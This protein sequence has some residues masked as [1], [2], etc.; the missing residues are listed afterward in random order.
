[1]ITRGLKV[2]AA[3]I[4]WTESRGET[5]ESEMGAA[6]RRAAERACGERHGDATELYRGW[7][8]LVADRD[9]IGRG[10]AL[11]LWDEVSAGFAGRKWKEAEAARSVIYQTLISV[12]SSLAD[13]VHGDRAGQE[14]DPDEKV[15]VEAVE[16]GLVRASRDEEEDEVALSS[17]YALLDLVTEVH[18]SNEGPG[19]TAAEWAEAACR[20]AQA[21]KKLA[22][23]RKAAPCAFPGS[24]RAGTTGGRDAARVGLA[25]RAAAA[26]CERVLGRRGTVE[27]VSEEIVR[28]RSSEGAQSRDDLARMLRYHAFESRVAQ[29][30][31]ARYASELELPPA[32]PTTPIGSIGRLE[33]SILMLGPHGVGKTSF[34]FASEALCGSASEPAAPDGPYPPI[35]IERVRN[36]ESED[37]PERITEERREAWLKGDKSRDAFIST[38]ARV[39]PKGLCSYRI[40]DTMGE[41]V[42]KKHERKDDRDAIAT[43]IRRLRDPGIVALMVEAEGHDNEKEGHD[44]ENRVKLGIEDTARRVIELLGRRRPSR[45]PTVYLIVNKLDVR[46]NAKKREQEPQD[47]EAVAAL[48]EETNRRVFDLSAYLDTKCADRALLPQPAWTARVLNWIRADA[49]LTGNLGTREIILENVQRWSNLLRAVAGAGVSEVYLTFASSL[50]D[51]SGTAGQATPSVNAF[52]RHLWGPRQERLEAALASHARSVFCRQARANAMA[53]LE[54]AREG[55]GLQIPVQMDADTTGRPYRAWPGP[56]GDEIWRLIRRSAMQRGRGL[57]SVLA[58]LSSEHRHLSEWRD[59]TIELIRRLRK[60]WEHLIPRAVAELNLDPAWPCADLGPEQLSTREAVNDKLREWLEKRRRPDTNGND[61]GAEAKATTRSVD[62]EIADALNDLATAKEGGKFDKEAIEIVERFRARLEAKGDEA[63]DSYWAGRHRLKQSDVDGYYGSLRAGSLLA[64]AWPWPEQAMELSAWLAEDEGLSIGERVE[65]EIRQAGEKGLSPQTRAVIWQLADHGPCGENPERR[66]PDYGVFAPR[67]WWETERLLLRTLV[68]EKSAAGN[69]IKGA[70]R[71]LDSLAWIAAAGLDEGGVLETRVREA[72]RSFLIARTFQA[73]GLKR[74]AWEDN[75]TD[76]GKA[77]KN[78]R[79]ELKRKHGSVKEWMT[80]KWWVPT[81][82]T[83]G[84]ENLRPYWEGETTANLT[85]SGLRCYTRADRQLEFIEACL[86]TLDAIEGTPIPRADEDVVRAVKRICS[87][88]ERQCREHNKRIA[89]YA[90]ETAMRFLEVYARWLGES[91]RLTKEEHDELDRV[92]YRRS[93]ATFDDSVDAQPERTGPLVSAAEVDEAIE[94]FGRI[95]SV[96]AGG[97]AG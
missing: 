9:R 63:D 73:M 20:E 40:L 80:P 42:L 76:L 18:R 13:R 67:R 8:R 22:N 51:Q 36:T 41:L 90:E 61:A 77:V 47:A 83:E 23:N 53:A 82:L 24:P 30:L 54:L 59:R 64:D 14:I 50:P 58:S 57:D 4:E 70:I 85:G 15:W 3:I 94:V 11:A 66:V 27:E 28:I 10:T 35:A 43:M 39:G 7:T 87:P 44:N 96:R 65:G 6:M 34:L 79:A 25:L 56:D 93:R 19:S 2:D 89:L 32:R 69:R 1:M 78:I 37:D 62:R 86:D 12:W 74:T 91:V 95:I 75:R 29:R 46:L 38:A 17:L 84:E 21:V 5:A 92:V 55:T 81:V 68:N 45:I 16:G 52:W 49:R 60:D 33:Q 48:V 97:A 31:L 88:V 72:V 26:R 71:I